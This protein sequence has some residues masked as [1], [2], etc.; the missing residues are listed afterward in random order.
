MLAGLPGD[1]TPNKRD[2]ERVSRAW[3][4]EQ[5]ACGHLLCAVSQS[6]PLTALALALSGLG[7]APGLTEQFKIVGHVV[8]EH[9]QTEGFA[10]LATA[11]Q[12]GSAAAAV[13]TGFLAAPWPFLFSAALVAAAALTLPRVRRSEARSTAL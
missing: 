7:L 10:W 2:W 5:W 1:R 4:A 9:A 3:A 6:L 11:G 12:A 8:P 13:V